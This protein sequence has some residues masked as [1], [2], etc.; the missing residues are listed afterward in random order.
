M[1]LAECPLFGN[2]NGTVLEQTN[3]V[4]HV[5]CKVSDFDG[6]GISLCII[7]T[8]TGLQTGSRPLRFLVFGKPSSGVD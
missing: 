4:N 3:V 8:D 7:S 6:Y 2:S 5:G 1:T